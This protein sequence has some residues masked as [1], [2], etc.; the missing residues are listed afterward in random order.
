MSAPLSLRRTAALFRA[1]SHPCRL[2]LL[3]ALA[4]RQVCDVTTMVTLCGHPQ[5]YVSQQLGILRKAGLVVGKTQ[6]QRV[7]Y[8]LASQ[9][10]EDILRAAGLLS[11]EL[12]IYLLRG[13]C[14]TTLV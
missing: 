10:I 11:L 4:E 8:R 3:I 13:F 14:V 7:C 2:R 12:T 5:P 1:L 6:G 9:Q